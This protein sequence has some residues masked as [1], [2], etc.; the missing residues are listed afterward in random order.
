MKRLILVLFS[1]VSLATTALAQ[2][3]GEDVT[4]RGN[5]PQIL[6]RGETVVSNTGQPFQLVRPL[7][8]LV[9]TDHAEAMGLAP[10]VFSMVFCQSGESTLGKA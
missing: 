5:F 6:A 9:L 4:I 3:K 1:L 2:P 7:D 8:F 10:M